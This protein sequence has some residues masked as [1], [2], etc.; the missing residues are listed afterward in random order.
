MIQRPRPAQR[1]ER[2]IAL[3]ARLPAV[4]QG[5][6]KPA[7]TSET[8]RVRRAL[9]RPR[10]PSPP[11]ASMTKPRPRRRNWLQDSMRSTAIGP[12]AP[13]RWPAAT[14]GD[15]AGLTERSGGVA[16]AGP[17]VAPE[18]GRPLGE[19]ADGGPPADCAL[20]AL[21]VDAS[22]GRSRSCRAA[23]PGAGMSRRPAEHQEGRAAG[24][25]IDAL[26][27]CSVIN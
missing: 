10:A 18:A 13:R 12:P 19:G 15:G 11:H 27:R 6:N 8:T 22:V 9:R 4:L 16:R 17:R 26:I 2:L 3:E 24:S 1:C 21:N 20:V 5:E 14:A 25:E 7:D 23:G